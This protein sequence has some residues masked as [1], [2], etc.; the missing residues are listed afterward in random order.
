MSSYGELSPEEHGEILQGHEQF[1]EEKYQKS[2]EELALRARF[3]EEL[4]NELYGRAP[5]EKEAMYRAW[6]KAE[7]L[8]DNDRT[9]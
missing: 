8:Q 6:L 3:E 7:K 9:S 5:E 4:K 2:E 1:K